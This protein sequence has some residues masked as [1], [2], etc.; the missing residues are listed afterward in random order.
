MESRPC[1]EQ[2]WGRVPGGR[3]Q[4]ARGIYSPQRH[5]T[6]TLRKPLARI[7][8]SNNVPRRAYCSKDGRQRWPPF[9]QSMHPR[10]NTHDSQAATGGDRCW[11]ETS[12][13]TVK[14]MEYLGNG[15]RP[16]SFEGD[17]AGGPTHKTKSIPDC[18]CQERGKTGKGDTRMR[19]RRRRTNNRSRSRRRRKKRKTDK[20]YNPLPG[21]PAAKK[22]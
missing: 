5:Q 9:D 10:L 19:K 4:V 12:C 2:G 14:A 17:W 8:A 13:R 7:S 11:G 6:Q 20:G 18:R 22:Q 1:G 15:G 3:A 21:H 16:N